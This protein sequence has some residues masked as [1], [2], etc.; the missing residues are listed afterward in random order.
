METGARFEGI[1]KAVWSDSIGMDV[2]N[3]AY[4]EA[5]LAYLTGHPMM[6]NPL[7][8]PPDDYFEEP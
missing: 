1:S 8:M 6:M 2:T 4:R 5:V 7:L 3:P